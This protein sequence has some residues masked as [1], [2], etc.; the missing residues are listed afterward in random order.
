MEGFAITTA[1]AGA[2]RTV[3]ALRGELDL[4][5]AEGLWTEIDRHLGPG[6]AVV[7]DCADLSFMDSM[8]LRILL[9]AV[10]RADEVGGQFAVAALS[11]DVQRVIVLSG[12]SERVPMH[13]DLDAA[14]AETAVVEP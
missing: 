3:V 9:R 8:G 12:M 6:R 5:T 2:N 4:A 11:A 7:L 10:R 13:P 1:D 14:L